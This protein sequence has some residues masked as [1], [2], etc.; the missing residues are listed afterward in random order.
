MSQQHELWD[1]SL[2]E[3]CRL[4]E[5]ICTGKGLNQ[6]AL[7]QFCN[8]LNWAFA[9]MA[10]TPFTQLTVVHC[11]STLQHWESSCIRVKM[12]LCVS[13]RQ[14]KTKFPTSTPQCTWKTR[15]RSGRWMRYSA[16]SG[17]LYPF[18]CPYVS[19]WTSDTTCGE[20][21]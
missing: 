4:T 5:T 14:R 21:Q 7:C 13:V 17:T 3:V 10:R 15:S 9:V 20:K 6:R 18:C 16:S 19:L 1:I 2:S 8:S 11:V 12:T